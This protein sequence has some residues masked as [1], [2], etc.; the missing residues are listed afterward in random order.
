MRNRPLLPGE[1]ARGRRERNGGRVGVAR[2]RRAYS[3]EVEMK[4]KGE[5][6]GKG[7]REGGGESPKI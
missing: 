7:G 5:G 4:K 3:R 6:K 1:E 2:R